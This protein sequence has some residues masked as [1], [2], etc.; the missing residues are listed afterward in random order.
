MPALAHHGFVLCW[1]L[2]MIVVYGSYGFV[3]DAPFAAL[4]SSILQNNLC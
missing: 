4:Y 2:A 1:P 3:I